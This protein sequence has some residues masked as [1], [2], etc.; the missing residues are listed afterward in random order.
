MRLTLRALLAS[1]HGLLSPDEEEQLRQK[2]DES[3][4]AQQ[5]VGHIRDRV[6]RRE[7]S[8]LPVEGIGNSRDPNVIAEYLDHELSTKEVPGV[9]QLCFK[10]DRHLAEVAACHQIINL[11]AG[12]PAQVSSQFRDRIYRIAQENSDSAKQP[13]ESIMHSSLKD[14]SLYPDEL[15]TASNTQPLQQKLPKEQAVAGSRDALKRSRSSSSHKVMLLIAI[16]LLFSAGFYF[17]KIQLEKN[18][19]ADIENE[20]SKPEHIAPEQTRDL[21]PQQFV[22]QENR[23]LSGVANDNAWQRGDSRNTEIAPISYLEAPQDTRQSSEST[24]RIHLASQNGLI[25]E[26]PAQRNQLRVMT[27]QMMVR[28]GQQLFVS[29][30]GTGIF[31]LGKLS[32]L[33]ALGPSRFQIHSPQEFS[34]GFGR[35]LYKPGLNIPQE[36]ELASRKRLTMRASDPQ[37]LVAISVRHLRLPGYNPTE[38]PAVPEIEIWCLT[39]SVSIGVENQS[40]VH[41]RPGISWRATGQFSGQTLQNQSAPDWTS[42]VK[43]NAIEQTAFLQLTNH[44]LDSSNPFEQL[45]SLS[46]SSS[47]ELRDAASRTLAYLG[48]YGSLLKTLQNKNQRAYWD[49][50]C[51]LLMNP[52]LTTESKL[53]D[54]HQLIHNTYEDSGPVVSRLLGGYSEKQIEL[55]ESTRLINMLDHTELEVRVL[56]FHTLKDLTGYTLG[57]Q[58]EDTTAVRSHAVRMWWER[59]RNGEVVGQT[60]QN[61]R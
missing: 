51:Q 26:V 38:T 11:I 21:P 5:L 24:T 56:A 3:P 48:E 27:P 60:L 42:G 9:E 8:T 4:F 22:A 29:P 47:A 25:L 54:L 55:G 53:E 10:S 35:F 32:Q 57:Y 7:L 36:L 2:I 16:S 13:L 19:Q 20:V 12:K 15:T 59:W 49:K 61:H 46:A 34:V 39:G 23:A 58:P 6:T 28:P 17:A 33:V 30:S 45:E 41:L 14:E 1:M 52:S 40:S 44:L 43:K 18:Q 37:T 50:Q 31:N